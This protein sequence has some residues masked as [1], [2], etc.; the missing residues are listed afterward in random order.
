MASVKIPNSEVQELLL[1]K[2]ITYP[3]YTTQLMNLANQNAQ[4]TRARIVGQMS[5]LIQQFEGKSLMEWDLWYKQ[6]HPTSIDDATEKI[7]AMVELFKQAITQIDKPTVR[8][9]VEE[10]VVTKTFS[11]LKFQQAILK[12]VAQLKANSF[13][14]ATPQEESKGIDGCI[15]NTPVSI[16]PLTYKSKLGLNESI[17][18]HIIYYNKTKDGL[19]V[20]FDF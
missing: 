8:K 18:V 5:E 10:L 11:G 15:G 17:S 16:K 6:K 1:G 9:W 20:E 7:F 4:G 12:K 13:R 14:L 19:T 2:V 3:K